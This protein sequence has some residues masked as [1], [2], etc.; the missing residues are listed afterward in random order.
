M[1]FGFMNRLRNG[2][3]NIYTPHAGSMIIQVQRETGLA[4]RTIVISE[5][6]VAL[7]RVL[8]SRIGLGVAAVFLATWLL[9]AVQ[10]V[11]VP[12]LSG[13]IAELERDNR[14]ID[15][16]QVALSRMHGRYEQVRQ[17]LAA[18]GSPP[19]TTIAAAQPNVPNDVPAPSDA[20][21][22]A[23]T[24]VTPLLRDTTRSDAR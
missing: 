6:R 13:R 14:R 16:L 23:N 7:F 24:P 19:A 12:L 2:Y 22:A 15:S 4:N 20:A 21:R 5:R 11:R 9:F 18:G 3:G 10:S 17:M 8:G 1:T